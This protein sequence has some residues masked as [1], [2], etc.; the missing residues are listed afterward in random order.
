[1]KAVTKQ[2][3]ARSFKRLYDGWGAGVAVLLIAGSSMVLALP[4]PV[5][6]EDLPS[7]LVDSRALRDTMASDDLLARGAVEER[8]DVDV[9]AVG[10]E[11]RAYNLAAA[12]GDERALVATRAALSVA[13]TKA[14]RHGAEQLLALRAYQTVRFVAEI[15]RWQESGAISAELLELG[16]DFVNTVA[17]NRWCLDGRLVVGERELRA[18]FKKRWNDVVGLRGDAFELTLD[19]DRVRYGFL[20]THPFRQA[21][22]RGDERLAE[23]LDQQQRL[24]LVDRLAERDPSYP[25]NLARGVVFYRLGNYPLATEAFRRHLDAHPNGPYTLRARNHLKAALDRA[26]GIY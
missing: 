1:L 17:R 2:T 10:R 26:A 16:G 22:G 19:E 23:V 24:R 13:V 3:K 11:V 7:P 18:L 15:A 25:A 21:V 9:R 20:L 4:R 8:L 12:E 5:A 6:P 14:W